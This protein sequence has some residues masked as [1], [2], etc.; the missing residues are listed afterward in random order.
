MAQY[1]PGVVSVDGE[2]GVEGEELGELEGLEAV[3]DDGG[4]Y[5][6]MGQ[7][8]AM[9]EHAVSPGSGDVT[10]DGGVG[11]A[12]EAGDLSESGP[13]DAEVDDG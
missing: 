5:L 8:P 2:V 9:Q 3:D 4:G 7:H 11:D 1:A 13:L 10:H 12:Q 6:R